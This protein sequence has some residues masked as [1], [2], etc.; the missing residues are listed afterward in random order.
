MSSA[1]FDPVHLGPTAREKFMKIAQSQ[2]TM[3]TLGSG[4]VELISG[5]VEGVTLSDPGHA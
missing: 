1:I 4:E 5:A 3:R 2:G